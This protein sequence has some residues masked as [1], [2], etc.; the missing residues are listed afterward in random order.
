MGQDWHKPSLQI[1]CLNRTELY[2]MYRMKT[3]TKIKQAVTRPRV[4][5]ANHPTVASD[6]LVNSV[7]GLQLWVPGLIHR[8]GNNFVI[9][10]TLLGLWIRR[11]IYGCTFS[12]EHTGA[13]GKSSNDVPWVTLSQRFSR[14][15]LTAALS[16][17]Q[18]EDPWQ[19]VSFACNHITRSHIFT[20]EWPAWQ[21]VALIP[22]HS[23][24]SVL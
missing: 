15:L 16:W 22:D 24:R 5:R 10:S 19:A 21:L 20:T 9:H 7:L 13:N 6:I 11:S 4:T 17:R 23:Y 18:V 8:P 12:M 3:K 14:P 2:P 1:L